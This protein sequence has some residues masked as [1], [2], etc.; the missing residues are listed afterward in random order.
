MTVEEA[1]PGGYAEHSVPRDLDWNSSTFT[2]MTWALEPLE[3][4][5][6]RPE[7]FDVLVAETSA[8]RLELLTQLMRDAFRFDPRGTN[9]R[10][11]SRDEIWAQPEEFAE[12]ESNLADAARHLRVAVQ[13]GDRARTFRMLSLVKLTCTDCHN[14]FREG[15]DKDVGLKNP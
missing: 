11:R 10:S 4:M 1:T 15:G 7:K 6:R 14:A 13:S 12:R 9:V 2:L 8:R 3:E 5:A